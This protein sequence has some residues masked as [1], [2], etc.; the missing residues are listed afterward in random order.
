MHDAGILIPIALVAAF[1]TLD[2]RVWN[3][4]RA[5]PAI[6]KRVGENGVNAMTKSLIVVIGLA[7]VAFYIAKQAGHHRLGLY[8]A[9]GI[10]TAQA[11]VNGVLRIRAFGMSVLSR[12]L[13]RRLARLQVLTSAT[14]VA[15]YSAILAYL[16]GWYH[17]GPTLF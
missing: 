2:R 12:E 15:A 17:L 7:L 1:L 13:Y 10:M 6:E 8:I 11:V 5:D 16:L 14:T 3:L 9:I 4:L